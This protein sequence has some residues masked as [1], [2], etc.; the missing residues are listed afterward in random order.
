[1][2]F[3]FLKTEKV[4]FTFRGHKHSAFKI[5]DDILYYLVFHFSSSGCQVVA[6]DLTKRTEL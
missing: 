6:Y 2:T 1:M 4:V 5:R 3:S